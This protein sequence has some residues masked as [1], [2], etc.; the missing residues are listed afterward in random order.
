MTVWVGSGTPVLH[1][2]GQG[3]L[4]GRLF[5]KAS[6]REVEA[7]PSSIFLSDG[8][9][10]INEYWGDYICL[11]A[12]SARSELRAIRAPSGTLPAYRIRQGPVTYLTSH[13]EIALDQGLIRPAIDWQFVAHH[14]AFPHLRSA[15]TGLVGVDEIMPGE[16]LHLAG[17]AAST[18]SL[19]TPWPFAAPERRITAMGEA[20]S[21]VSHAVRQAIEALIRPADRVLL[22]LSG[23]LDSSIIAAVMSDAGREI[24]ALNLATPD[25]GG[26]ERDYARIVAA[27]CAISLHEAQVEEA[28]DLTADLASLTARPGLPAMLRSADALFGKL[29]KDQ[30]V[31]AYV[32]GTGGDCVFC[33][34][35]SATPASD[36]LRSHGPRPAL[37]RVLR[38]V[39]AIHRTNAWHVTRLM[40]RQLRR[41]KP[42]LSWTRNSQFLDADRLP[43]APPRH[44]WL[45]ERDQAL[46]GTCAHV[47]AIIAANAHLDGY[48]RQE[49]APSLYPLLAQPVV[50]ACLAI[51]TW[52]WVEGGHDRAVARNAFRSSLPEAI[53]TRRTKGS[54]D[55]FC[56][57]IFD[58]N[59][60]RLRPFLLDGLLAGGG[61]LDRPAIETY[62]SRAFDNRDSLFY[63][64]L[65][66]ADTEAWARGVQTRSS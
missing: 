62:L 34:L 44:P 9:A 57:R 28:I 39:A 66:I 3:I 47:R 38:D 15:A 48:G 11:C 17:S 46:P 29:A 61:L 20:A 21:R 16:V 6:A 2:N 13:I 60:E 26:D 65:P 56:A 4:I 23:G 64:L 18:R 45:D 53:V 55:A 54:M 25:P 37:A 40:L 22:E 58:R 1:G 52:L 43:G 30:H 24:V 51:P 33:S 35:S 50:E 63:H 41:R 12:P 27:H 14:L 10:L 5:P 42:A 7:L 59:R 32:S 36:H 19:W 31:T 8:R 49:T